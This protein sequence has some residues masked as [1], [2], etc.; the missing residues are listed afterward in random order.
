MRNKN[1]KFYTSGLLILGIFFLAVCGIYI[2]RLVNMQITGVDKYIS[3][4]SRTYTRYETVQAVRG[5]IFDRNG[6]PL[7]TNEYTNTVQLSYNSLKNY[8]SSGKN[9]L[10]SEL[11][12]VL[13]DYYEEFD[14]HFPITGTYPHVSYDEEALQS[15]VTKNRFAAFLSK[16]GLKEDISAVDF[17]EW[18]LEYYGVKT[19]NGTYTCRPLLAF[20]PRIRIARST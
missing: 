14:T 17:F 7:I 18:L 1:K 5:E 8:T 2:I 13:E 9:K 6:K 15:T 11:S 12:F 10:I 4:N 20:T 19:E 16:N 3:L